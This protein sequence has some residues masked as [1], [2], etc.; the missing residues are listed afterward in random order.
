MI[1]LDSACPKVQAELTA[2]TILDQV[3]S[4]AVGTS[5]S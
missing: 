5:N 4:V 1:A 2:T 3:P